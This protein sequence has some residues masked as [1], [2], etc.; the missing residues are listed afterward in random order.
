MLS[1]KNVKTAKF[2]GNDM[3]AKILSEKNKKNI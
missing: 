3:A 1:V 2:G